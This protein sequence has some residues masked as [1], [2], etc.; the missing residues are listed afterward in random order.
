M[1][2][3]TDDANVV[4]LFL[5]TAKKYITFSCISFL[6]GVYLI[7]IKGNI[8]SGRKGMKRR[9]KVVQLPE[10]C[11]ADGTGHWRSWKEVSD[12]SD[13]ITNTHGNN[14]MTRQ[15][16]CLIGTKALTKI[17]VDVVLIM[18]G[19]MEPSHIRGLI[20]NAGF[21]QLVEE[22]LIKFQREEE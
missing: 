22:E 4:Q 21:L 6:V 17:A 15:N 9:E 19:S 16:L 10:P 18:G 11:I 3:Y 20:G 12:L 2:N 7:V 14:K 8:M 1:I 13:G 5:R